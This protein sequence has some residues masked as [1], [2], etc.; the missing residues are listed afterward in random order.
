M[1]VMGAISGL[2]PGSGSPPNYSRSFSPF[3]D[4]TI[5]MM[6]TEELDA[7]LSSLDNNPAMMQQKL[8]FWC[9]PLHRLLWDHQYGWIF[10]KPVDAVKLDL[11]DYHEVSPPPPAPPPP[12][13]VCINL[14]P[15]L[16][17]THPHRLSP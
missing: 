7:H 14:F 17:T 6:T 10:H 1:G 8:R 12:V 3:L 4:H 13:C 16:T 11:P 9:M 15:T 5:N 2:W